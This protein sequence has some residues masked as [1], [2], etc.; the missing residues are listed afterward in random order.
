MINKNI[1]RMYFIFA[2]V[3]FIC[4]VTIYIFFRSS[5]LLI[6]FVFSKPEFWDTWKMPL[7][8][9]SVLY[10]LLGF[11][12]DCFWLL[13]GILALRCLWFFELKTQALYIV[14]FY[15]IAAG[16]NIGQFFK[17]IPG[18]FDFFD[19]LTMLSVALTEGIIFYFFIKRRIQNDKEKS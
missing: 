1:R 8:K 14:I 17:I 7:N 15:F 12:P 4:G 6:W 11:L 19:F 16:Y 10:I 2:L 9:N 5:D 3:F 13:S 18:T